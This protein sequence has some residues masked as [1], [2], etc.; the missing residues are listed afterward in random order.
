MKTLDSIKTLYENSDE[1]II[2][3]DTDLN[4]IWKSNSS[5]PDIIVLSDFMPEFGKPAALP[6]K[7]CKIL[8]YIN[9]CSVKIKPLFDGEALE[10]YMLTFFNAEEIET[11][12]DRSSI[13]KYKRN[14]LGNIRLSISPIIAQLD[15]MRIKEQSENALELYN[16]ISDNL[17]KM[18]SST[19]NINELTKYYSGEFSTELLNVSQCLEETAELCRESFESR[20]C[21]FSTEIEPT[22]FMNMNYDRLSRA[23]L[24]LL[25]NGY[26][27]CSEEVKKLS[28]K[29][30]K[31]KE[32]IIIEISDNGKNA[33]I[34]SIEAATQ[35]FRI[36]GKFKTGE[37]LGLAVVGKFASHFNGNLEFIQNNKGFTVKLSFD[38]EIS[39]EPQSFRLKRRPPIVGDFEPARCIL[40]KG[41][42]QE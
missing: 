41:L 10:G 6:L 31:A 30:Y 21:E 17:L 8:H 42:N 37:S 26:M 14:S 33:D 1:N 23:I 29:A 27:Y 39:E 38:S 9:G 22:I 4:V 20:N 7:S 5:L 32:R 34:S 3:T 16:M 36:M 28:L 24:N 2:V 12:S 13:L 18:L 25:I 11:L 15:M 19:V 35:P 40:A